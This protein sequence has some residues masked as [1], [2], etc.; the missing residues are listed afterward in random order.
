MKKL[1][2][3]ASIIESILFVSGDAVAVKDISEKLCLT[4]KEVLS[5]AEKLQKEKYNAD[6]GI[7]LL[8]FNKKLQ[9]GT[10]K[11][12]AESVATVLNPIKERELSRSMLE[13]AAIIAYKQPVT[14]MDLEEIRN[15]SC[16]Y[17]LQNL[18]KLGV[19]EVVGR[20]DSIGHPA[21]FGTTDNFLKRFQI[22]SLDELPDY[23]GLIDKIKKLHGDDDA[24]LFKKDVYNE[25]DDPEYNGENQAAD[26]TESVAGNDDEKKNVTIFD[27][28]DNTFGKPDDEEK[29]SD[30][31]EEET[32]LPE[33]NTDNETA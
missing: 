4:D 29:S 26:N 16:E 22:S 7:H 17:A 15:C 25:A 31:A 8:I 14:R 20:K 9:F 10:N 24:Y 11:N 5:I 13:V 18:I 21:L 12:N 33:D 30:E 6:S 1:E 19:V 23:D 32:D 28:V 27:A 2:T 3:L